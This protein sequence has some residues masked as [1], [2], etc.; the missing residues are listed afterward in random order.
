MANRSL[1]QSCLRLK[2]LAQIESNRRA[3]KEFDKQHRRGAVSTRYSWDWSSSNR[4][5]L[6]FLVE[7]MNGIFLDAF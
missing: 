7:G 3:S 4:F 5:S 6:G 1:H 2:G